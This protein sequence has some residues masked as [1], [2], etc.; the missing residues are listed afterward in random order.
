MEIAGRCGAFGPTS[1]ISAF[2]MSILPRDPED[3]ATV[4]SSTAVEDDWSAVPGHARH[5]VLDDSKEELHRVGRLKWWHLA[6]RY[7]IA[8]SAVRR[9]LGLEGRP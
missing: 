4:H 5:V 3:V 7:W 1:I 2:A 8:R 9:A 6:T